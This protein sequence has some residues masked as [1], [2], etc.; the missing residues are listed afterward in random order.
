MSPLFLR[1]H[2]T[3]PLFGVKGT[4]LMHFS[5]LFMHVTPPLFLPSLSVRG[6]YTSFIMRTPAVTLIPEIIKSKLVTGKR[7]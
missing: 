4:S 2:T 7:I 5:V 6:H 3:H 1:G